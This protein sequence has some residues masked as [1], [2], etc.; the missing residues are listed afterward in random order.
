MKTNKNTLQELAEKAKADGYKYVASV[1]KRYY[2]TTYYHI[3]SVDELIETGKWRRA[4][5]DY[6]HNHAMGVIDS[7]ID[8]RVT[9]RR[10]AMYLLN[11][12]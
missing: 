11:K 6:S 10:K 2:T 7:H 8:W 3:V 4:G 1:I 12:K 5:W 9:I